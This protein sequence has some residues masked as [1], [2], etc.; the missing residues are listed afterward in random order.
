M[1]TTKI[2][3]KLQSIVDLGEG[4]HI[5]AITGGPCG[6][7]TT[8]LVKLEQML[9]DRGYKVL[10][11][12]ESATKLIVGG[13]CPWET[14]HEIFQRQLILDTLMQEE[15]FMEAAKKYRDL[16]HKVVILCDRGVMDG[17]AY[18]SGA[19]EFEGMIADLGI[20]INSICNNRYHAIIHLRTAADGAEEFY[21]L[22]NNSARKETPEQ[23]RMFDKKILEAWQRHHHPRVID[24]YTDFAGKIDRLFA[25]VCTVLGDPEPV[26]IEQK[27]LIEPFDFKSVPAHVSL[28][29]IVQDYLVSPEFKDG[30]PEEERRVRARSDDGGTSYFYTI[31]RKIRPGVRTEIER[32]IDREEYG[33]LLSLKDQKYQTIK[34]Q[35]ACFFYQGQF[36]EVDIFASPKERAGLWLMEIEQSS[37]QRELVLPPF[38]KVVKEVTD[39]ENYSNRFIA[40]MI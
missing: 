11:S 28:S 13:F 15:R 20:S 18:T 35:R 29:N 17:Q 30:E 1:N 37:M 31:K 6:G 9:K 22:E 8:G 10:V 40:K 38:V 14:G 26:E 2:I 24:N 36:I 33:R 27:F 5:I 4:I 12:P 21:T 23:A 3:T 7:K 19:E 25:E 16:G 32:I 39:D 34:K